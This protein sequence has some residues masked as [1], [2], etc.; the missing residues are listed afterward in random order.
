MALYHDGDFADRHRLIRYPYGNMAGYGRIVADAYTAWDLLWQEIGHS[1]YI[2]TGTLA[3]A[4]TDAKWVENS[5]AM[6]PQLGIPMQR[7]TPKATS[8]EWA[9]FTPTGGVLLADKILTSLAEYLP[10]QGV[11]LHS[12]TVV[13]EI[14]PANGCLQLENGDKACETSVK[15]GSKTLININRLWP[16][17]AFTPLNQ[18]KNLS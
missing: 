4:G 12:H 6:L 13:T 5:A 10:H 11:A 15:S 7:L 9:L 18:K 3:L 16:K 14:D 17:P 1:L 8:L 2:E